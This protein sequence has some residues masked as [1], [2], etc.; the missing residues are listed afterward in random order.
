MKSNPLSLSCYAAQD[1]ISR[2]NTLDWPA[3]GHR[4]AG[5]TWMWAPLGLC[6]LDGLSP[7]QIQDVDARRMGSGY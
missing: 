4:R 7:K 6:P 3:L 2:G 5:P 1:S